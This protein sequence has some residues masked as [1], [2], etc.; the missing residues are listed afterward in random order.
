M[1]T[2]SNTNSYKSESWRNRL[3]EILS[4]EIYGGNSVTPQKTLEIRQSETGKVT[5]KI[6]SYIQNGLIH[7]KYKTWQN[8]LYHFMMCL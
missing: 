1:Q 4:T 2:T 3:E 8:K 5:L 7:I 6:D